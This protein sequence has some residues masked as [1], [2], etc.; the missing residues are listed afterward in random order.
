MINQRTTSSKH[1]KLSKWEYKSLNYHRQQLLKFGWTKMLV[2]ICTDSSCP[3]DLRSP[4]LAFLHEHDDASLVRFISDNVRMETISESDA[5]VYLNTSA[6]QNFLHYLRGRLFSALVL[7]YTSTPIRTRFV[8]NYSSAGS[9]TN[10]A[11]CLNYIA[12]LA[13]GLNSGWKGFK[14]ETHNIFGNWNPSERGTPGQ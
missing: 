9:T 12:S 4:L 1:G 10:R 11:I 6:G 3:G 14:A 5:G 2:R 13:A 7:I 8:K